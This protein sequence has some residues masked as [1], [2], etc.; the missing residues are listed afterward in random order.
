[1]KHIKNPHL[2]SDERKQIGILDGGMDI[3]DPVD[4]IIKVILNEGT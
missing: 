2:L 3:E 1:M 4:E